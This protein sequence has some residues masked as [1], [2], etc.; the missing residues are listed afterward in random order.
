MCYCMSVYKCGG[1]EEK[2]IYGEESRTVPPCYV[3]KNYLMQNNWQV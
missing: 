2:M 3:F 1:G